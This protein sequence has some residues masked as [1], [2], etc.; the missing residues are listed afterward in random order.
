MLFCIKCFYKVLC[1]RISLFL[2]FPYH[3]LLFKLILVEL[4]HHIPQRHLSDEKLLS[5]G[6]LLRHVG[7]PSTEDAVVQKPP[8]PLYPLC[9]LDNLVN[10]WLL[11]SLCI[12]LK[13]CNY[14]LISNS[15]QWLQAHQA[16]LLR[17]S[18]LGYQHNKCYSEEL[19]E[20]LAISCGVDMGGREERL[21]FYA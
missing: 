1:H 15:I 3:C 4:W 12:I 2:L 9:L 18:V 16:T 14:Y 5:E 10:V 7:K 8:T 19:V 20:I 6:P 17:K 11:R 13:S 21:W